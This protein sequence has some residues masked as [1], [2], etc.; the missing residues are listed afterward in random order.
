MNNF[1]SKE[2]FFKTIKTYIIFYIFS[3]IKNTHTH[4]FIEK[5]QH[6]RQDHDITRFPKQ[7]RNLKRG[8]YFSDLGISKAFN[9]RERDN[10]CLETERTRKTFDVKAHD[11]LSQI[12]RV[13]ELENVLISIDFSVTFSLSLKIKHIDTHVQMETESSSDSI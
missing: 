13:H 2:I 8:N 9:W 4:D 3:S 7:N 11:S 12:N 1:R 6:I 10:N 5:Q